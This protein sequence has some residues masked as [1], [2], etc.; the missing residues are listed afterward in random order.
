M[1]FDL[2]KDL[3]PLFSGDLLTS[4]DISSLLGLFIYLIKTLKFKEN[5]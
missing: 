2:G 3:S 5:Y 4:L 1:F